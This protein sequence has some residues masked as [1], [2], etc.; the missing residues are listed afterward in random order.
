[1]ITETKLLIKEDTKKPILKHEDVVFNKNDSFDDGITIG[2]VVSDIDTVVYSDMSETETNTPDNFPEADTEFYNNL[3]DIETID[4]TLDIEFI[5][6]TPLHPK[7]GIKKKL[8]DSIKEE[9]VL[10]KRK[11]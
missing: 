8:R 6:K 9:K 11:E 4:Y 5:K 1:M 7:K 3:L 2:D 10:L